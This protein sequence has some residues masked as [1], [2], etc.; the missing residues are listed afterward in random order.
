MRKDRFFDYNV[1][2]HDPRFLAAENTIYEQLP[3]SN[4]FKKYN[5]PAKREANQRYLANLIQGRR[6]HQKTVISLDKKT[7]CIC[8]SSTGKAMPGFGENGGHLK[9]S[10]LD[11]TYR[12]QQI[13]SYD[14]FRFCIKLDN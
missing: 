12:N 10:V 7:T 9:F 1:G 14:S 11:C 4:H 6:S 13:S 5:E 8:R 3:L 2:S